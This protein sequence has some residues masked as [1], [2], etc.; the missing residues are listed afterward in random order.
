L[1]R[2]VRLQPFKP[3]DELIRLADQLAERVRGRIITAGNC[4]L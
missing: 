3:I 4:K 2:Q 1:T